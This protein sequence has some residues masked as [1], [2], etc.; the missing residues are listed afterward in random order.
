MEGITASMEN[1]QLVNA[2]TSATD[3]AM[4]KSAYNVYG[5][6]LISHLRELK[7]GK[8]RVQFLSLLVQQTT[9]I[10][11]SSIIGKEISKREWHNARQHERYPG[12]GKPPPIYEHSKLKVK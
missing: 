11:C 4:K 2:K 10:N 6:R 7:P 9:R 12:A 5:E 8:Q 1:L 3:D